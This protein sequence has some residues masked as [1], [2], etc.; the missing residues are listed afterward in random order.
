MG[1]L[2]H[3]LAIF[4]DMKTWTSLVELNLGSNQLTKL[5][6]DIDHLINLEVLILSNN[7]L[8]VSILTLSHFLFW[9]KVA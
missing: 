5:P 1:C 8:K 4:I 6:D 3:S 7:Q 9:L 2:N